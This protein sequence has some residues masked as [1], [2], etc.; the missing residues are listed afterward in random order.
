MPRFTF[1]DNYKSEVSGSGFAAGGAAVLGAVAAMAIGSDHVP[2]AILMVRK[3]MK[4]EDYNNEG[5]NAI[6]NSDLSSSITALRKMIKTAGTSAATAGN[7][8]K[9]MDAMTLKV[10]NA[11]EEMD[12]IGIQRAMTSFV[13]MTVQYNPSTIQLNAV[14]AGDY[15]NFTG[16][17][18]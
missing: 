4:E 1:E 10:Q 12:M 11:K 13:G 9:A 7:S 6:T 3:P 2:K 8:K 18:R 5:A 15:T 16:L 14:A 17:C